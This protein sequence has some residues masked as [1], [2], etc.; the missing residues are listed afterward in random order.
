MHCCPKRP[1]YINPL[2]ANV[3]N[4]LTGFYMRAT[5]AFNGL[6]NFFLHLPHLLLKSLFDLKVKL[7]MLD[8]TEYMS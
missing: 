5:M 8:N 4:Q 1:I 2:N 7:K 3:A 6:K